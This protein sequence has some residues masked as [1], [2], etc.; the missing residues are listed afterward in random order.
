MWRMNRWTCESIFWIWGALHFYNDHLTVLR[1]MYHQL[2][3]PTSLDMYSGFFLKWTVDDAHTLLLT[4]PFLRVGSRHEICQNFYTTR[5]SGQKFYTLKAWLFP[6]SLKQRKC[7]R[8]TDLGSILLNLNLI[9]NI[10]TFLQSYHE[11][12]SYFHTN[13][14]KVS[15]TNFNSGGVIK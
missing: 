9:C 4:L 6:L 12:F 15:V 13:Y 14:A 2:L 3:V 10:F 1:N 8:I 7:I 5:F 11:K